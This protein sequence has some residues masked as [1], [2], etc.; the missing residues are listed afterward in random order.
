M[1]SPYGL[2]EAIIFVG[3]CQAKGVLDTPRQR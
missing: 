2:P 3:G 1:F